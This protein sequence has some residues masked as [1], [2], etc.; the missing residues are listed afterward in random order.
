MSV[1]KWDNEQQN[2]HRAELFQFHCG[3]R[4]SLYGENHIKKSV[5]ILEEVKNAAEDDTS[6]FRTKKGLHLM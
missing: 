3:T 1:K 2:I 4:Y 6:V 5:D